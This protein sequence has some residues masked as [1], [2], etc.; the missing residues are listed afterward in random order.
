M[1]GGRGTTQ[2][3]FLNSETIP[4]DTVITDISL[5][6]SQNLKNV[7]NQLRP[8]IKYKLSDNDVSIYIDTFINYNKYTTLMENVDSWGGYCCQGTYR[9][10][11]YFLLNFAVNLKQFQKK[12]KSIQNGGGGTTKKTGNNDPKSRGKKTEISQSQT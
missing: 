6:I 11:L 8:N 5:N 2:R 10:S 4:Y 7:Q 9:N 12:L 3:I 1:K